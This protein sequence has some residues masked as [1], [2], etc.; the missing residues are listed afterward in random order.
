MVS[1]QM[2]VCTKRSI[3]ETSQWTI[4]FIDLT[5]HTLQIENTLH[6]KSILI[7]SGPLTNIDETARDPSS[8]RSQIR[9]FALGSNATQSYLS[10]E[11]IAYGIRNPAGFAF[12]PI[13]PASTLFVVENGASIDNVTGL[14]ATFVNDNPADELE[15]VDLVHGLGRSYGFPDCTT[16][17]NP[18]ADP[19][20]DPQYVN[21]TVGEQFSLE[22]EAD[23]D[24]DWC[25]KPQNNLPPS[26]SF[27]V[28][29]QT[30]TI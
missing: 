6:G 7:A 20:G 23:R 12:S 17:W 18:K 10:G 5:T 1:H 2:E 13:S 25:S 16:I 8:G 30:F 24:N 19:A 3:F 21:F 22:L 9:R 26:L 14:T 15:S 27:Q 11:L 4:I 29:K 28:N